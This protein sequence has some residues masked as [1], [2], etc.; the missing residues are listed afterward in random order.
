MT[1][2]EKKEFEEFLKWKA[3]KAQQ[4]EETKQTSEPEKVVEST[5]QQV[6]VTPENTKSS[7]D[8]EKGSSNKGLY[9]MGAAVA[10]IILLFIIVGLSGNKDNTQPPVFPE[11]VVKVDVAEPDTDS[12]V[13][14]D[15]QESNVIKEINRDSIA[16]EMKKLYTFKR[17]EFSN[18]GGFWVLP[19][20]KPTYRNT[21]SFYC[22]FWINDYNYASNFRFVMQYEADSWLFIENC[23]FN[24]DGENYNYTPQKME[25]DN[26]SR[27]WEWFDDNISASNLYLIR[28]IANAKSVKVKLNGRQYY[29]TRTIKAK[30]IASIKQ[31]LEYFEKLDGDFQ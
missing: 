5:P 7:S 3:E 2:D 31:T 28:L 29:D 14:A 22:Y 24:I 19:K 18:A 26:H 1:E 12:V 9:I 11:G 15:T 16:T 4:A 8:V 30:E 13:V 21:N 27:I 25:R 17:D 6:N 10:V 20:N 23:V